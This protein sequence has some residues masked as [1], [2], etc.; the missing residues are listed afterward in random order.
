MLKKRIITKLLP[1]SLED[2]ISGYLN[3]D[4]NI[5]Q[6]L[7]VCVYAHIAPF[8]AISNNKPYGR[9]VLSHSDCYFQEVVSNGNLLHG[10]NKKKKNIFFT[11]FQFDYKGEEIEYFYENYKTA[12]HDLIIMVSVIQE[13][14]DVSF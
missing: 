9:I 1:N 5:K 2:V 7:G 11:P 3:L 4:G 13:V 10:G 12:K 8:F 14:K 6:V